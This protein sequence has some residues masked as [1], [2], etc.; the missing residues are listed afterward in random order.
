MNWNAELSVP[1]NV[2]VRLNW[3]EKF[4]LNLLQSKICQEYIDSFHRCV[5]MCISILWECAATLEHTQFQQTFMFSFFSGFLLCIW[6]YQFYSLL[7]FPLW[8]CLFSFFYKW[9]Q[10][11][12]MRMIYILCVVCLFVS[13]SL[14][15]DYYL[16][17]LINLGFRVWCVTKC[18]LKHYQQ[19]CEANSNLDDLAIFR[20]RHHNY[21]HRIHDSIHSVQ[22]LGNA[23][24]IHQWC[25]DDH[26][27]YPH[28]FHSIPFHSISLNIVV[29][30]WWTIE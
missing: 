2:A 25:D 12:A 6:F 7:F 23:N 22:K 19:T 16:N 27:T 18:Y 21:T 29:R 24:H 17:R 3:R 13:N 20:C 14:A 9:A 15:M 4:N 28:P 5:C 30:K 10:A 8:V 1:H 26:H 11:C